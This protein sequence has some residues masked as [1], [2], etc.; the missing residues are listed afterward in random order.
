MPNET[1]SI[2]TLLTDRMSKP[3]TSIGKGLVFLKKKAEE[4]KK[5]LDPI[6][7]TVSK[8]GKN[9]QK[10]SGSVKT[11]GRNMTLMGLAIT[12]ALALTTKASAEFEQ[13]MAN[14]NTMLSEQTEHFMPQ[15]TEQ[16]KALSI[17]IGESTSTLSKGLYDILS[18]SID[19]SKAMDVLEVAA[20]AARAGL[21][22][23]AVSADAITTV[24]NAYGWEA[25]R[26]GEV[27]DKLFAIVKRGK[28]T[29]GSLAPNIGKV[30][31]LA[32]SAGLSF[33]E[34]GAA[35]S[36]LTR[37]GL[38]TEEAITAIRG[39]LTNFLSPADEA[40]KAAAEL[41]IELNT[42]TLKGEGLISVFR[43][44][45]NASAEQVA[46]IAPNVRALVGFQGILQ[47]TAGFEE[48]LRIQLN[49]AGT[50]AEAFAKNTDTAAFSIDQMKAALQV[51]RIEIG[52]ALAP[53]IVELSEDIV[54]LVK[55]IRD[56]IKENPELLSTL[57]GVLTKLA[58]LSLI[59]G[60]MIGL[61]GKIAGSWKI[62]GTVGKALFSSISTVNAGALS[63]VSTLGLAATAIV[64]TIYAMEKYKAGLKSIE[65]SQKE[66]N[67]VLS[68]T[69]DLLKDSEDAWKEYADIVENS[70]ERA[71][72]ARQKALLQENILRQQKVLADLQI[73]INENRS[74]SDRELLL[75]S[76]KYAQES[77]VAN[78]NELQ[79]LTNQW[80][81]YV[82]DRKKQQE[83]LNKQKTPEVASISEDMLQEYEQYQNEII[84]LREGQRAAD[85]DSL[86]NWF[87]R[88]KYLW[89]GNT[90]ELATIEELY[91]LKRTDLEKQAA[92]DIIKELNKEINERKKAVETQNELA[93][94][95][96]IS[97]GQ[98]Q[99]KNREELELL[100]Q[101]TEEAK[102]KIEELFVDSPELAE[103]FIT[104][105]NETTASLSQTKDSV[106]QLF[107]G[108]Q[109][110]VQN[111]TDGMTR[112]SDIGIQAGEMMTDTISTGLSGAFVEAIRGTKDFGD[113]VKDMA[114]SVLADLAKMIMKAII[115][116]SIMAAF[117]FNGG[118]EVPAMGFDSGGSVPG[119]DV[120][121]DIVPAKLTPG[122]FVHK[123]KAVDY[124]GSGIMN[125]LNNMLIPKGLLSAFSGGRLADI[126]HSGLFQTGGEVGSTN[127]QQI[128]P[129]Y[130]VADEQS[131]DR[132]LAGGG[133]AMKNWLENNRSAVRSILG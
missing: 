50:T 107:T 17:G 49:A 112:W 79:N 95:G 101:K 108:F 45:S 128:N 57:T 26:A 13:Q 12:G 74:K 56:W 16:I 103:E 109:A 70:N 21:T 3:L 72:F 114:A 51:A 18:A 39:V 96:V 5:K 113:A 65:R 63:L 111:A 64:L 68:K 61:V 129:A 110:G 53:L 73:Q 92:E 55:T 11:F 116:R 47:Q 99:A 8:V 23:T 83:E 91:Q 119:P 124:Y 32:A 46:A 104:K 43:K 19:A 6:G 85:I 75:K 76:R 121:R 54:E 89:R 7:N 35:I 77:L 118:G 40:K 9:L 60:P 67:S 58:A 97:F 80:K 78:Q 123:K 130:I 100:K 90:E 131:M 22:S 59:F 10:H 4:A 24:L 117:G 38:S 44:L 36:T 27:S 1:V 126:N 84:S 105:I 115:L 25:E 82:E 48:D 102:Q 52:S 122:E 62:L 132:L 71:T 31:T 127:S 14:V 94:S 2:T 20:K 81:K 33:E 34:L 28:T 29:F 41:G 93:Q 88:Q 125:A 86:E 66:T 69:V 133:S 42:S 87:L 15:Y 37:A 120:N 106:D 30:A 98:A